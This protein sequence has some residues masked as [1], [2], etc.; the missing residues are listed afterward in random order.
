MGNNIAHYV[1]C[2]ETG[3]VLDVEGGSLRAG[4]P[5]VLWH[6]KVGSG[7]GNQR[8]VL[9]P[10]NFIHVEHYPDLVLDIEN[11]GGRGSRVILWNRKHH[12]NANQ[13]WHVEGDNIISHSNGLFLDVSGGSHKE[14]AHLIIWDRKHHDNNTQKFSF[15]H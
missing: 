4:T 2:H 9:T 11:A 1:Q 8:W 7:G 5:V 12:D 10:D 3:F 15:T 14:G 6:K 13:K